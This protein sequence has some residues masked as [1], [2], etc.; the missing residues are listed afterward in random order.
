MSNKILFVINKNK[1]EKNYYI[2]KLLKE[3]KYILINKFKY[4]I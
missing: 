3:F 4:L 1:N 2:N